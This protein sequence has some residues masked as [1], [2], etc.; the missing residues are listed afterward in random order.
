MGQ[1]PRPLTPH[2]SALHFFGAEVRH[3][4][5]LR[6]LSGRGLGQ[7]VAY[8]HSLL[9]QIETATRW[10]TPE[11]AKALDE[12]LETGGVLQ[13][14]IPAVA[15]LREQ[16]ARLAAASSPEPGEVGLSWA[17]DTAAAIGTL[18]QLCGADLSEQPVVDAAWLPQALAEPLG[19][20]MVTHKDPHL[21]VN[22]GSR[23]VGRADLDALWAMSAAFA[24]ADHRL[25]GGHARSTLLSYLDHVLAPM[26]KGQYTDVIG[27]ELFAAAARLSDLAGF[28]CFDSGRQGLGQRYF[29]QAL[30]L[31]KISG[32]VGL[33]AH[34]LTDMA[35][36]A[37]WLSHATEAIA[38]AE[39]ACHTVRRAG[40]PSSVARCHAVR[41]RALALANDRTASDRALHHAE[42]ALEKACHDS[43]P[44]WI[45]FFNATQLATESMY[46]SDNLGR[47][48]RVQATAAITAIADQTMQRRHVLAVT[49]LAAPHLP[50]PAT[51]T[52]K[53]DVDQACQLLAMIIP[54]VPSMTSARGL[55][56]INNIRRR[57]TVFRDRP[58]VHEVEAALLN[59]MVPTP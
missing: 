59:A 13:R 18:R 40:S 57:L 55:D 38:L 10:P 15:Q 17:G 30:R 20:W 37:H 50:S 48:K 32:A 11:L 1:Q 22:T 35:M 19:R 47:R 46:A 23:R 5:R 52:A 3:W 7:A 45:Q 58:T 28:M 2:I 4:R 16:S 34:I 12:H 54:M 26:L 41:A 56:G 29:V 42:Q 9:S 8:S 31:A 27:R 14:L 25:G 49:T 24:D 43:E 39:A 21:P 51:D 33:G 53:S 44:E 36:Q 6:G